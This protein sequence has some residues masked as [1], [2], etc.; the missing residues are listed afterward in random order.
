MFF[1][2]LYTFGLLI[3][4]QKGTK[5]VKLEK[6]LKSVCKSVKYFYAGNVF[7]ALNCQDID[8]IKGIR[9][10]EKIKTYRMPKFKVLKSVW[11]A[12]TLPWYVNKIHMFKREKLELSGKNIVCGILDT[13]IDTQNTYLSYNLAYFYDAVNDSG[14]PY[15]DNGHGTGIASEVAGKYGIAPEVKLAVCKGFFRDGTSNDTLILKCANWFYEL[16]KQGVPLMVINNSWGGV[17]A[18][19]MK[20][21]ILKWDSVS[22]LSVFSA[23]NGGPFYRTINAPSYYPFTFSIGATT[24]SDTASW[25]SSRGP[26]PDTGIFSDK[27]LWP[28][29]SWNYTKPDFVAPG[30]YIYIML[31]GGRG[32]IASGTSFSAAIFSGVLCLLKEAEPDIDYKKAYGIIKEHGVEKLPYIRYPDSVYGFG[33]IDVGKLVDYLFPKVVYK[34]SVQFE[35]PANLKGTY[36]IYT[37]D[38]RLIK[39]GEM[40]INSPFNVPQ[41]AYILKL[42]TGQNVYTLKFINFIGK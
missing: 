4:P 29:P 11:G 10:T 22:I 34:S 40:P 36:R 32:G 38:G 42:F 31:P 9:K 19:Y 37:I 18:E 20:D 41:G 28:I 2:V 5:I 14:L 16:K 23:G 25:Y 39:E 1:I 26:A 35:I 27:A 17:E 6:D 3:Y 7:S 33:R 15:D 21:I 8:N 12:D 13:G 24:S 30:D